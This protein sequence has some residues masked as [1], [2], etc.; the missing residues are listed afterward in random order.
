MSTPREIN[1]L[2][3]ACQ[4]ASDLIENGLPLNGEAVAELRASIEAF[5][6]NGW[7]R[8]ESRLIEP[9]EIAEKVFKAMENYRSDDFSRLGVIESLQKEGSLSPLQGVWARENIRS[10]IIH[11]KTKAIL[12]IEED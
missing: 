7:V 8:T 10:A 6:I 11:D 9:H 1:R 12:A 5:D 3:D 4:L 2:Y